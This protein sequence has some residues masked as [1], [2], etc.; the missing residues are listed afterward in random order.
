MPVLY[1]CFR[2]RSLQ[3]LSLRVR[4]PAN[5]EVLETAHLGEKFD[6]FIA[7]PGGTNS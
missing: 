4:N 1:F 7:N 2:Q 3:P 5:L 6:G